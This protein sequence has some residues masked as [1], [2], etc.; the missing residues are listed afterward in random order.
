MQLAIEPDT[1][2]FAHF[3]DRLIES[4]DVEREGPVKEAALNASDLFWQAMRQRFDEYSARMGDWPEHAESTVKRRGAGAPILNQ[5]GVLRDSMDRGD[6]QHFVDVTTD[7]VIEGS[8]D[9]IGRY[10]QDGNDRLPQRKILD[11]PDFDTMELIRR[12]LA[13]GIEQSVRQ[14]A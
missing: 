4:I 12:A 3:I 8:S 6:P 11:E 9:P 5:T 7:S 2:P 10:H 14:A 1:N 13:E